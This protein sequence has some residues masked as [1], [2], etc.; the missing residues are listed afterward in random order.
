[1][2]GFY[3]A[4]PSNQVLSGKGIGHGDFRVRGKMKEPTITIIQELLQL[5][6]E[7]D[8]FKGK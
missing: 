1:L 4:L 6:A 3:L 2:N 5:I 8:E 7:L